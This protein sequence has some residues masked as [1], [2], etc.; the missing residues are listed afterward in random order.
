MLLT[1]LVL[2]SQFVYNEP[3]RMV[4]A[5]YFFKPLEFSPFPLDFSP[6]LK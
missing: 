4:E 6:M 3:F 5:A 2:M 1:D